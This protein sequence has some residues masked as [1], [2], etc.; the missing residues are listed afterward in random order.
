VVRKLIRL[1]VLMFDRNKKQQ[2][3]TNAGRLVVGFI[4]VCLEIR[5]LGHFGSFCVPEPYCSHFG[6]NNEYLCKY[7]SNRKFLQISLLNWLKNTFHLIFV[8]VAAHKRAPILKQINFG[9]HVGE[10]RPKN[11]QLFHINP[12]KRNIES[13]KRTRERSSKHDADVVFI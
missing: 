2:E 9:S 6:L 7:Y 12:F 1:P 8:S 11:L 4:S 13:I 5:W 3:T 10:E